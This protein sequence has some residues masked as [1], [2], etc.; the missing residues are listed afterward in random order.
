[1]GVANGR[2]VAKRTV[3]YDVYLFLYMI[4]IIVLVSS[5]PFASGLDHFPELACSKKKGVP[6]QT[7]LSEALCLDHPYEHVFGLSSCLGLLWC[8]SH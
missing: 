2:L 8:P 1:M 4:R 3:L 7:F 6:M 5:I